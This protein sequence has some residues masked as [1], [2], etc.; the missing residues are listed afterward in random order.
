MADTV[1]QAI[2]AL[3][4]LRELVAEAHGAAKDLRQAIREARQLRSTLPGEAARRIDESVKQGL[5]EYSASL[6][7]GIGEA[8][9]AVYRRFD[10]IVAICLGEDPA[11]VAAGSR[12]LEEILSDHNARHHRRPGD[13]G[14][15]A[16]GSLAG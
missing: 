12:T 4:Q 9:K 13:G 14:P 3:T 2:E 15:P 6:E 7:H 1:T 8:T 10:T 5:D 11:S 16:S